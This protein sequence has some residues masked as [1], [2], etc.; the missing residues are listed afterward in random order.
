M[1]V[2]HI[3]L[4]A[5]HDRQTQNHFRGLS[6]NA[7]PTMVGIHRRNFCGLWSSVYPGG[8]QGIQ[9]IHPKSRLGNWPVPDG[10]VILPGNDFL[11][12]GKL[13]ELQETP[14]VAAFRHIRNADNR[15]D[16][17]LV[18]LCLR[19]DA[20]A[21]E[22]LILRYR[23]L[24]YS[25]PVKFGFKTFD[26]ADVFQAV[27]VSLL[28]HLHELKDEGK[29]TAWLSTTA[30]RQCMKV[31]T[32]TQKEL[33]TPNEDFEDP[34]DPSLNLEEIQV[35]NEAQQDLRDCVELLPSKCRFLVNMLYFDRGCPTYQEISDT[36]GIPVPA[37]GPNRGRCLEK[38]RKILRMHGIKQNKL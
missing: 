34:L 1:A 31:M 38:L 16:S 22:T 24:I 21:W 19:G 33:P 3:A 35:L 28:E 15:T 10:L 12:T 6:Q 32:E 29:I 14:L 20:A 17:E 5:L 7:S 13:L 4:G 37:I 9:E 18:N 25:F 36:L 11:R 2:K 8:S 26:A 23:R 27:C 30:T